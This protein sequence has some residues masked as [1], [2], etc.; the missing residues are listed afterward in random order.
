VFRLNS[1]E[2]VTQRSRVAA[3]QLILPIDARRAH[4][5]DRLV[6]LAADLIE[7]AIA[8]LTIVEGHRQVFA[9][10]AGLPEEVAAA[11]ST[12][13][14]YS[15]CQHAVA[16]GRPLI[17][18]DARKDPI[19]RDNR[20]VVDFGLVAYAGIPLITPEKHAVGTLC[21]VDMIPRDWTDDHVALLASLA[22]IATD[23]LELQRHER[24]AAFR[25]S[26]EGVG[27]LKAKSPRW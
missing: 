2:A 3:A 11:G 7:T 4:I 16:S 19:L 14:E 26:W 21:V 23:E 13:L 15:I 18:C 1:L 17:V 5:L 10:H 25:Q 24:A 22:D 9:A 12:P 27:E 8:M 6:R 20:A